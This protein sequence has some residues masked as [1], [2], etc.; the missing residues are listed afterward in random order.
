MWSVLQIS[1]ALPF[2]PYQKRM[3]S[4]V[5]PILLRS[6]LLY[7]PFGILDCTPIWS[8]FLFGVHSDVVRN[9]FWSAL[10]FG[11]RH[12]Q[13]CTPKWSPLYD[14]VSESFTVKPLVN[15]QFFRQFIVSLVILMTKSVINI[16]H[17][18]WLTQ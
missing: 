14:A 2:G 12:F 6:A 9:K 18:N 3:H 5:V 17:R 15:S 10:P 13:K 11:P 8:P 4:H 1:S 7:G 16:R